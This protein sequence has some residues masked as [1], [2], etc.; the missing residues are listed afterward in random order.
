MKDRKREKRYVLTAQTVLKTF[1]YMGGITQERVV[2]DPTPASVSFTVYPKE[3]DEK[4]RDER[5]TRIYERE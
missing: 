3:V 1:S 5:P 2:S 4:I